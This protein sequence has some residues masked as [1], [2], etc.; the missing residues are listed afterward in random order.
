MIESL[1]FGSGGS[2]TLQNNI[3]L[4]L[5]IFFEFDGWI[6][7]EEGKSGWPMLQTRLQRSPHENERTSTTSEN[8]SSSTDH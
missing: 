2:V 4:Y 8:Q 1:C 5:P 6:Q 7:N 3:Q